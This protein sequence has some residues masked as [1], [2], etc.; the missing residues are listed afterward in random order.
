MLLVDH[1]QTEVLE[2]D[3]GLEQRVGADYDAGCAGRNALK[4]RA[5]FSCRL[6]AREQRDAEA[7][8]IRQRLQR[9]KMLGGE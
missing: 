2:L 3:S 1:R 4:D 7:S 5:T 9:T 6:F 8:A